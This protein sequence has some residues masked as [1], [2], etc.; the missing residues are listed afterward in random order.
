MTSVRYFLNGRR[1][2]RKVALTFDDGPTP[3]ITERVIE[4]LDNYHVRGTFFVIGQWAAQAEG[5]A[6]L[7]RL[8]EHHH[9]IGN[10]SNHHYRPREADPNYPN[11]EFSD[12][13]EIIKESLG[14]PTRFVRVPYLRYK[15]HVCEALTG[16]V[17]DRKI[18]DSDVKPED[19]MDWQNPTKPHEII[20]RVLDCPQLANGSII[21]LH[22][23]AEIPEERFLRPVATL[24]ALPEIIS[25]L[26]AR[27]FDIV[28]LDDLE[29]DENDVIFESC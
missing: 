27:G 19:W 13:E 12:A 26:Q 9:V 10:H 6:T 23:G 18:I 1:D 20:H 2:Q 28:G 8:K 11:T 15:P 22:D 24:R 17:A 16:W 14:Q 29:F 7:H 5:R 25:G 3:D 21:N 4:I